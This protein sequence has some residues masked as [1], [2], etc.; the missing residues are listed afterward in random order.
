M[1]LGFQYLEIHSKLTVLNIEALEALLQ[2]L[3]LVV[4]EG[5]LR[6]EEGDNGGL[7]LK[8]LVLQVLSLQT[9]LTFLE[10]PDETDEVTDIW[11]AAWT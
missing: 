4:I 1:E 7:L 9:R 8:E 10:I 11:W 6:L 5:D 3:E 2:E